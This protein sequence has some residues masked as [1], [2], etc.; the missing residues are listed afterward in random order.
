MFFFFLAPRGNRH[1]SPVLPL[2]RSRRSDVPATAHIEYRKIRNAMDAEWAA[3]PPTLL[4]VLTVCLAAVGRG[5]QLP[6]NEPWLTSSPLLSDYRRQ[7]DALATV[8]RDDWM[9]RSVGNQPV[10]FVFDRQFY[11]HIIDNE[12]LQGV[13][14]GDD[15]QSTAS[16]VKPATVEQTSVVVKPLAFLRNLFV[17]RYRI[18]SLLDAGV[19]VLKTAFR[20]LAYKHTSYM[21]LMIKWQSLLADSRTSKVPKWSA[22]AAHS[23]YSIAAKMAN[24]LQFVDGQLFRAYSL[25]R[26]LSAENPRRSTGAPNS[27]MSESEALMNSM[28][29][30]STNMM[31]FVAAKCVKQSINEDQVARELKLVNIKK[32]QYP[33]FNDS[34]NT[35]QMVKDAMNKC[36]TTVN[37]HF[38]MPPSPPVDGDSEK[39]TKNMWDELLWYD[40]R[41]T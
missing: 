17:S 32:L 33:T 19:Q 26:S 29:L 28:T 1:F 6:S 13:K 15:H 21:L 31:R 9:W 23:V 36:W 5:H 11:G 20:C 25:F 2:P 12:L 39:V 16:P 8:M 38:P 4:A 14:S 40:R 41:S 18:G 22:K 3:P 34:Q 24:A 30:L 27:K 35:K 37:E 7:Y 10:Y